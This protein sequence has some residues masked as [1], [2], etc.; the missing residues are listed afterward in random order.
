[1]LESNAEFSHSYNGSSAV[2]PITAET[3]RLAAGHLSGR[4][5]EAVVAVADHM[6]AGSPTRL[7]PEKRKRLQKL[8][9]AFAHSGIAGVIRMSVPHHPSLKPLRN[10]YDANHIRKVMTW[11]EAFGQRDRLDVAL[12]AYEGFTPTLIS[13]HLGKSVHSV[14]LHLK[15]FEAFG[16]YDLDAVPLPQIEASPDVLRAVAAATNVIFTSKRALAVA[17]W[18]EGCDI[19]DIAETFG[20][21][22]D[23]VLAWLKL[24][25]RIGLESLYPARRLELTNGRAKAVLKTSRTIIAKRRDAPALPTATNSITSVVASVPEVTTNEPS[26]DEHAATAACLA[27]DIFDIACTINL[28]DAAVEAKMTKSYSVK[29]RLNAISQIARGTDIKVVAKRA[30]TKPDAVKDWV[31]LYVEGGLK[32]ILV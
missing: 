23:D 28:T 31:R 22:E 5:H 4:K 18:V 20:A 19:C 15:E 11:P 16:H 7:S 10:D 17:M 1:M 8:L 29:I 13:R 26:A 14:R 12:L 9:D 3:L 25:E 6:A 2:V 30:K 21:K 27:R 24:F 32:A